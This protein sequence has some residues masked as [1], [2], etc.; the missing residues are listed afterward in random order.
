MP[1]HWRPSDGLVAGPRP[2]GHWFLYDRG[3]FV[4]VIENGRVGGR[5]AFRGITP[6]GDPV[7]YAW[8]LELACNTLWAWH[9]L[10]KT[11]DLVRTGGTD[12]RLALA[13]DPDQ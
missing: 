1:H 3:H 8:S 5:Q 7:G 6:D 4:G 12:D 2:G 11:S 13:T 9:V 10:V